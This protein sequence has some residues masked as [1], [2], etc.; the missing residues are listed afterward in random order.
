[1]KQYRPK[2]HP[3]ACRK[4]VRFFRQV[5]RETGQWNIRETARRLDVN[6]KYVQENL[7]HG[8]EPTDATESGRVTRVKIFLKA[9]KPKPRVKTEPKPIKLPKW[10]NKENPD[11]LAWFVEE[12][13]RVKLMAN[14]MN[15]E[16]ATIKNGKRPDT[17]LC[18]CLYPGQLTK[19]YICQKCGRPYFRRRDQ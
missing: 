3:N 6:Q 9:Y 13:E 8:I 2:I 18:S 7:I 19:D 14:K 4:L 5:K 16:I 10:L 1:M 12:R 17:E 15:N 11:A